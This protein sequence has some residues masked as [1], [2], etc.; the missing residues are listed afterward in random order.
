MTSSRHRPAGTATGR[1]WVQGLC[2]WLRPGA[3]PAAPRW[4]PGAK[5]MAGQSTVWARLPPAPSPAPA[6]EAGARKHR[7]WADHRE[8]ADHRDPPR[9]CGIPGRSDAGRCRGGRLTAR[10]GMPAPDSGPCMIP[11]GLRPWTPPGTRSLDPLPAFRASLRP[12][13]TDP[14]TR[15]AAAPARV[16]RLRRRPGSTGPAPCPSRFPA[17]RGRRS[18]PSP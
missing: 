17:S 7:E 3:A 1:R 2:P 15:A 16:K 14:A 6:T 9:C 10:A 8:S 13:G 18:P 5:P 11:Q 12:R 4:G